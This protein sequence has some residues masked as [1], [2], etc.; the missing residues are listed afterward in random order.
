MN[1]A[2]YYAN[3]LH[4][5]IQHAHTA[6]AFIF[7]LHSVQCVLVGRLDGSSDI[8]AHEWSDLG[9]LIYLRHLPLGQL[10]I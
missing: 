10:Q 4:K 7:L 2:P 8:G 3:N 9:Y 6:I 1:K 5:L